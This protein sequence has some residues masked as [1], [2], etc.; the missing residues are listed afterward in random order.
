MAVQRKPLSLNRRVL[1]AEVVLRA[2][3]LKARALMLI[4]QH[5][6]LLPT[7]AIAIASQESPGV[8]DV[9]DGLGERESH[10]DLVAVRVCEQPSLLEAVCPL[11]FH[12]VKRRVEVRQGRRFPWR[13]AS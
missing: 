3:G 1:C 12:E 10:H 4:V 5:E 7:F 13:W 6:V 11:R 9:L 2:E 8:H